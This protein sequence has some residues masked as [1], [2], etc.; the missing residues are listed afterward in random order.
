MAGGYE[1]RRELDFWGRFRR[2]I[3]AADATV[4]ASI[5]NYDDVLVLLISEVAQRYVEL[6]TAEQRLEYAEQNVETQRE[7]LK[8]ATV[9]FTN[10]ATTRLDVTQGESTLG[11]TEAIIP[12]LESER[13]TAM[14]QICILLGTPPQDI[15]AALN[16]HQP[17]PSTPPEVALG[18]PADLLRRR[19]TFAVRSA[20][21]PPKAP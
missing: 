14:N 7:S 4:D 15:V 2:A 9:K 1:F 6:R 13:R 17:I 19:R 21:W 8:L 18:I 3:E 16:G 20:K 12:P 10:G 5:E 11:Q